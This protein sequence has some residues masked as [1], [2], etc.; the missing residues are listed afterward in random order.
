VG[1][2]NE[3]VGVVFLKA[4][5]NVFNVIFILQSDFVQVKKLC[6]PLSNSIQ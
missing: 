1:T 4:I 3:S 5:V 2:W 6:I